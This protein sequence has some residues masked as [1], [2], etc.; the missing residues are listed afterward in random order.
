[1]KQTTNTRLNQLEDRNTAADEQAHDEQT[2][3]IKEVYER[4]VA[5]EVKYDGDTVYSYGY[6]KIA[7]NRKTTK[8]FL[9]YV[10]FLAAIAVT[11]ILFSIIAIYIHI[12]MGV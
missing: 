10:Y 3:T 2:I 8:Q 6:M 1:M 9:G 11:D 12:T 4:V 5:L 7:E